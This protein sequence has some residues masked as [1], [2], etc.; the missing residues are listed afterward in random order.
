MKV[1]LISIIQFTI[2]GYKCG[3][4]WAFAATGALE[5]QIYLTKG[6]LISLSEQNLVDCSTGFGN[7]GCQYGNPSRAFQ[8][9]KSNGGIDTENSY[10]YNGREQSCRLSKKSIGATVR[11]FV[12]L[13][14]GLFVYF[15]LIKMLKIRVKH[16]R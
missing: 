5:G 4:C 1:C 14:T 16:F 13:P 3:A 6:Y 2:Q 8:Y 15:I 9:I 7:N 10:P 11:G 12:R